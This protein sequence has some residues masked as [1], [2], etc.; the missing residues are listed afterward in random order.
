M[1][2]S[3]IDD[4]CKKYRIR[5][6]I[7]NPDGSID[8]DGDVDFY[9]S[10]LTNIPLKFNKVSGGF[11]CFHNNLTSL[12]GS[13]IYVGANFACQYNQL[14]SLIGGPNYIGGKFYCYNNQL[15]NLEG[16]PNYVGCHFY[17]FDNPLPQEIKDNP[18]AEIIRLN[19]EKKLNTLLDE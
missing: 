5:N 14:T 12:E 18:K 8:V 9:N 1:K 4:I 2:K 13:P 19:R 11:Y 16:C 3:E 10:G 6:Y 17:C 15:T 7:I